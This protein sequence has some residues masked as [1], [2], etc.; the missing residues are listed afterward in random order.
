MQLPWPAAFGSSFLTD[1]GIPGVGSY[2]T[3]IDPV[4][5]SVQLLP[6]TPASAVTSL[7]GAATQP[8]GFATTAGA[9]LLGVVLIAI[10]TWILLNG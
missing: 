10:A 7:F 2:S 9:I 5:P 4:P 3:L 8:V 6:A 1:T